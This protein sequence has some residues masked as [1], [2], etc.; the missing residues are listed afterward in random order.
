MNNFTPKIILPPSESG[1]K[2]RLARL[3]KGWELEDVAKHLS[4]KKEYLLALEENRF[5]CLPSGLYGKNFIQRYARLLKISP[6]E[7]IKDWKQA[8]ES[9][10]D[11]NPFSRKIIAR[12]QLIALPKL[13]KNFLIILAVA[14]CFLYL[15][16]YFRQLVLPPRLTI[17]Y[18]E[19]NLSLESSNLTVTGKTESEA[20]IRING[21]IVLNNNDGYFEQNINLKKGLN[22]LV[23][24]AKKKYSR[25]QIINR[26]ILVE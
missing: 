3:E 8:S 25:E 6:D 11:S 26:Q 16:F 21:E 23:I 18:P 24:S 5:D 1:D 22:T 12:G 19:A 7:F 17:I 20:E 13:I 15:L 10:Q 4:I 9:S 14:I 2:L